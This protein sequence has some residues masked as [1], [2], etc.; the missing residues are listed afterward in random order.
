M[1]KGGRLVMN[2]AIISGSKSLNEIVYC[3][4]F[5]SRRDRIKIGYSSR[6]L[7]RILEQSTGFPENPEVLFVVH[8][9]NAARIEK[10]F[11]SAL[12]PKQAAVL[13]VEWFEA[14][15]KDVLKISPILRRAARK[16][17]WRSIPR[18]FLSGVMFATGIFMMP[19]LAILGLEMSGFGHDIPGGRIA[20]DYLASPFDRDLN[21]KEISRLI[22]DYMSL[23]GMASWVKFIIYASPA[24]W[25]GLAYLNFRKQAA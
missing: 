10:E 6:G 2:G 9:K 13:G 11:H 21:T 23:S 22:F 7:K 12:A 4:R 15:M 1:A 25:A 20:L 19:V 24:A 5:P 17:K 18:G 3:Y 16:E 14:S 8:H